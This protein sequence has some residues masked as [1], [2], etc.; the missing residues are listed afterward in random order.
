MLV[1]FEEAQE[2][3]HFQFPDQPNLTRLTSMVTPAAFAV[4]NSSLID[5]LS[6]LSSS[7]DAPFFLASISCFAI[8]L[9]SGLAEAEGT[10]DAVSAR[11]ATA[12]SLQHDV[13]IVYVGTKSCLWKLW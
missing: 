9:L 1:S 7:L 3:G 11:D 12:N 13:F 8:E 4:I 6:F 5:N 2:G 10:R